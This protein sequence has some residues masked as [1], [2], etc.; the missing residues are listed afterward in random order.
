MSK[1]EEISQDVWDDA[2]Q[3]ASS[4][5]MPGGEGHAVLREELAR[6]IMAAEKRG[7]ERE[8]ECAAQDI[9][10]EF[11]RILSKQDGKSDAVDGNIR[12]IA[13]ILPGLADA[14]RKRGEA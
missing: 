2:D 9:E 6:A 5:Q 1:P 12:M 13:C 14:I 11:A 3:V 8:R 7:E 10:N 4:C